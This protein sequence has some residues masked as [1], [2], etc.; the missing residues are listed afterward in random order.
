MADTFNLVDLIDRYNCDDRCR[1]TLELLRWPTGVCCT[2]CGDMDV[3]EMEK[4]NRWRCR[5]CNYQ[6]SVTSGTIM[7][8]SHCCFAS[9][10]SPSTS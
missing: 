1:D 7:H 3:Y 2:R 6:F 8:D 9:G 4:H 5:G 10:S